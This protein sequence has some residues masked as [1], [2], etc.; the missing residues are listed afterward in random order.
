MLT[1]V[2]LVNPDCV[3][4][5]DRLKNVDNLTTLEVINLI[6]IGLRHYVA[7]DIPT[8]ACFVE[9]DLNQQREQKMEVS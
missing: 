3:P 6:I 4:E 8:D 1:E 5:E 7:S 2:G 9:T